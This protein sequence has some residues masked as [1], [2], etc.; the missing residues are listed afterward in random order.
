MHNRQINNDVMLTSFKT[1]KIE[2]AVCAA[3]LCKISHTQTAF[4]CP[5]VSVHTYLNILLF[6]LSVSVVHIHTAHLSIY[7]MVCLVHLC[8][9]LFT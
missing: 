3:V 7:I 2:T 9:V 8:L 6:N 4:H 5:L 1:K